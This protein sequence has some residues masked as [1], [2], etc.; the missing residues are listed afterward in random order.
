MHDGSDASLAPSTGKIMMTA[1]YVTT[2][3]VYAV[4][5]LSN[6]DL[7]QPA[8]WIPLTV[9]FAA[10]T[11]AIYL[12]LPG[13]APLWQHAGFLALKVGL[14]FAILL[15]G[16]GYGYLPILYFIVVPMAYFTL[17]FWQANGIAALSM[18]SLLVAFALTASTNL[19]TTLISCLPYIGGML[20]FAGL[21][22]ALIRQREERQRAERLLAELEDA[23]RQ[24]QEYATQVKTLAVAEERN[25][26]AREIH[27]SL[28]HYLTAITM[29]LQAAGK[30]VTEQP[31][32]A[33]ESIA[34]AEEM[35]RESL[36]EVRRS[37]AALRASPLDTAVLGDA[38]GD[39]VG[40]FHE[41]GIATT[42][43]VKGKSR[44]LPIQA[45]TA[46]Y[47]VAQEGL[48]NVRKHA[49][50]SAVEVNLTYQSEKVTLSIKD[51][52][53]G[54]RREESEGFGLLGLR[55]RIA[56]LGGSLET[57]NNPEGGFRLQVTVPRQ[58]QEDE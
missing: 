55:E 18:L 56:L 36:A 21:T 30:L 44:S 58:V 41:G 10:F 8:I 14:I 1:A 31:E 17:P 16:R 33:A 52:G 6:P 25:R 5:L 51:N 54:Q 26:L 47:R 12:D 29:Q 45:K 27:D 48:T 49:N 39:L 9:L 28:G 53:T 32:R 42:F 38:I 22:T 50:A 2:A 15:V 46:L 43:S 23:H 37:V 34:K 11:L 3:A 19:G 13:T 40:E 24:L 57:G 7:R 4:T 20:F 35:A